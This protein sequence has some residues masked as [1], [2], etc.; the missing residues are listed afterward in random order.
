L[1]REERENNARVR[2]IIVEKNEKAVTPRRCA[3]ETCQERR[4]NIRL[5]V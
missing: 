3:E 1:P 4:E 5:E 2:G